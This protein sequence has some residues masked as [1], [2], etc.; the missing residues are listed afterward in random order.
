M[1]ILMRFIRPTLLPLMYLSAL[2]L[3]LSLLVHLGALLRTGSALGEAAWFLH[4]GIFLVWIPAVLVLQPLTRE[5]K[6]KDLWRAAL[7]G[8]PT[9]MRWMTYGFFGY[10]AV[11][12]ILFIFM[13]PGR[14]S[15][16]A[17]SA[18]VLRGFSGHWMAFYSAAVAIFYSARHAEEY[19]LGRRC[20][21]GHQVG[22]L[23]RYC[24]ECGRQVLPA[25]GSR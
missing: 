10:A 2:G 5:F 12:F 22:P 21:S 7:R 14:T 8:C 11:N 6:Q 24:E 17:T 19:D 4:G 20:P 16:S 13:A 15:S 25:A 9:W 18:V 3:I 1:G 23:A